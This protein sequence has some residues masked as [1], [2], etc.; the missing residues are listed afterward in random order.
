[1]SELKAYRVI[2]HPTDSEQLLDR[3]LANVPTI[4]EGNGVNVSAD[5]FATRRGRGR[6]LV[7]HTNGAAN[8]G[9]ER[10]EIMLHPSDASRLL[11]IGY[12]E[13]V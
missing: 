2:K 12:I 13:E 6:N 7:R 5:D 4:Q 11:A 3:E 1:M 8:A 9:F 10:D